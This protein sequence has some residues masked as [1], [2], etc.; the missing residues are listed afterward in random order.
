[1]HPLGKA[2]LGLASLG[3]ATLT[4]SAGYEVRAFRLRRVSIPC[5]PHGASPLKVLHLS[6]IHITPSQHRKVEWLRGLA[7]LEPDLVINT[8]DNLSHQDSV[9][10]VMEALGDLRDVPGVYVFGSNDYW[11]PV[12]KNPLRYFLPAGGK[13]KITGAPLPWRELRRAFDDVGWL[14]LSNGFGSLKVAGTAI[15]FAGVDDP[16]LRYD[17]L[18]A[19]AGPA[20]SGADLRVGVTHAPYLRVLDQFTSDGYDAIFAGHTHGGQLRVPGYGALV[21][22]CDI[23]TTRSRGLHHHERAGHRAWL[24]VSAG[25][26]T[27]PYAPIRFCCFPEATLVT[28]TAGPAD[29]TA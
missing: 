22:N 20:D 6:D 13:K 8:G 27:S 25:L 24:H 26:G 17:D 16:H 14:D 1:M 11:G 23:D 5:L 12:L 29:Q 19:V 7:A 3:A 2:A 21:T 15:A 4:Y 28:L 10:V 18:T 9:D